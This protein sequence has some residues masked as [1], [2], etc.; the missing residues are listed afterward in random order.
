VC[1]NQLI[2]DIKR[3]GNEG[4][5]RPE[6]LK[7]ALSGFWSRRID[8]YNRLVY[9]IQEDSDDIEIAECKGHYNGE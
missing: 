4:I 8:D 1:I 9:S 5:G 7:G 6:P 2:K 3:N